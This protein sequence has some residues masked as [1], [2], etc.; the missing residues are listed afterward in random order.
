MVKVIKV[1]LLSIFTLVLFS[2]FAHAEIIEGPVLSRNLVN[3][4]DSGL[5]LTAFQDVTLESFVFQ[6][7]GLADTIWL[8]DISGNILETYNYSGGETS[9]LID[10]AWD[11]SADQS[12]RII[13]DHASNGTWAYSP[14]YPLGNT[15]IQVDGAWNMYLRNTYWFNFNSIITAVAPEPVSSLLFLSG[16]GILAV[17]KYRKK[18]KN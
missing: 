7:Q 9:H 6:N 10:V 14:S 3:W 12:Y 17:W 1:K 8:T 2:S 18:K 11:L 5:Q 15:H 13:A 16:G 4:N